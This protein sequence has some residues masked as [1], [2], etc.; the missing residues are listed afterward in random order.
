MLRRIAV[1]AGLLCPSHGLPEAKTDDQVNAPIHAGTFQNPSVNVRPRFRYW[2]PDADVDVNVVKS[3]IAGAKA[4]GAGGVEV[5]GYYDYGGN[6]GSFEPTDWAKYGWGTDAWSKVHTQIEAALTMADQ[7][8]DAALEAHAGNGLIMDMAMGPNQGQGVPAHGDE[9]G[10]MWD[11]IPYNTM[12]PPKGMFNG[13]LPGW[14]SGK[15]QAVVTGEVTSSVNTSSAGPGLPNG[16]NGS[17]TQKTLRASSLTDVT[18]KVGK[19]GHFNADFA[20]ETQ[21]V[22]YL[23][24]AVY[25]ARSNARNQQPP[26]VLRGPQTQPQDWR[27]NGSWTVDH[28]SATGAKVVTDFWEKYVLTGSTKSLIRAVGNYFWEDS[29]EIS[30]HIYWTPSLPQDFER[31]HGYSLSKWFPIL[32]HQNSLSQVFDTW[33]ITDEPDSGNSHVADY[34]TTVS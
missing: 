29:I 3:D 15:L 10:L 23:I 26:G 6:A 5:L 21:G 8:F 28:F 2:I 22:E 24:M 4:A 33:F 34:R 18:S 31:D 20:H 25:L 1:V 16:A 27:Q 9:Q 32:F 13:T 12:V 7:I 17:R 14:G 19:D 11:I 30:P